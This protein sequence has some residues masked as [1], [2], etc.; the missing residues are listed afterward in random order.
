MR[1]DL[2]ISSDEAYPLLEAA[3]ELEITLLE[4]QKLITISDEVNIACWS[5]NT[6]TGEE[7][8]IINPEILNFPPKYLEMV[9][10]HEILH[11]YLYKGY[12]PTL[13]DHQLLNVALDICINRLLFS[14]YKDDFVN[15]C[16]TIYSKNSENRQNILALAWAGLDPEEIKDEKIRNLYKK[17]WKGQR[18]PSPKEIYY[19]LLSQDI[20]PTQVGGPIPF[21]GRSIGKGLGKG[22]KGEAKGEDKGRGNGTDEGQGE[23]RKGNGKRKKKGNKYIDKDGSL[24]DEEDNGDD[25][26]VLREIPDD[27]GQHEV[28]KS[29]D[30]IWKGLGDIGESQGG[31]FSNSVSDWLKIIQVER[32]ECETSE[33][34]D[35]LNRIESVDIL[36]EVSTRIIHAITG[37]TQRQLYPY[38][39]SRAGF[40]YLNA[41]ISDILHQY[42]NKTV[43]G[44][45]TKLNIYV[46]T[47]PSMYPFREQ[48]IFLIERFRDLFPTT[49]YVF[50]GKVEEFLIDDFIKG[51]YPGGSSTSFD[52]VIKHF[53]DSDAECGVVFTDGESSVSMHNRSNFKMSRKRLFTVYFNDAQRNQQI[54]SDLD[55]MSEAVMQINVKDK[56]LGKKLKMY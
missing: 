27:D 38:R 24:G 12:S 20:D 32:R 40:V 31:G 18:V 53:I 16:N 10:R 51:K 13:H 8:I 49:F 48:E 9:L 6:K 7:K 21:A 39:L 56:V 43:E 28:D 47:S 29:E 19:S 41:G 22:D 15:F 33:L 3:S 46:D 17:I 26:I 42:W 30:K 44:R 25:G 14:V 23:G 52:S 1:G 35:F 45:K 2:N 11:K 55:Y 5:Y 36:D 37:A 54:K 4:C 34:E 50:A